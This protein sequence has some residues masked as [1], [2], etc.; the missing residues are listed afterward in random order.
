MLQ[1]KCPYRR[2]S[3]SKR[4]FFEPPNPRTP[5]TASELGAHRKR[6]EDLDYKEGK[7]TVPEGPPASDKPSLNKGRPGKG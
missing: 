4:V 2:Q 7:L 1:I 3:L 5:L 6:R